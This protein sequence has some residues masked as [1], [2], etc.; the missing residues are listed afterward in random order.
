MA[1]KELEQL[2]TEASRLKFFRSED[3]LLALGVSQFGY[4]YELISQ[5]LLPCKTAKQ[6][7]TRA[8]NLNSKREHENPVKAFRR[9]GRLPMLTAKVAIN[10]PRREFPSFDQHLV[11]LNTILYALDYLLFSVIESERHLCF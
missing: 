8:K 11:V 7:K 3:S 4:D 6:L 9:E 10:K 5:Y 1:S 2:S